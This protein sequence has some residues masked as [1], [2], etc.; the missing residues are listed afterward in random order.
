VPSVTR[1]YA[2]AGAGTTQ[3]EN[4]FAI[5]IGTNVTIVSMI[6]TGANTGYMTERVTGGQ[7][8]TFTGGAG[9]I[10]GTSFSFS[11]NNGEGRSDNVDH[12]IPGRAV[13]AATATGPFGPVCIEGIVADGQVVI[14]H[15]GVGD[16]ILD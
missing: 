12:C 14:S 8:Q 10:G 2:V 6:G 5:P 13:S 1:S 4:G 11:A 3:Y 15:A 7:A 9:I 16:S